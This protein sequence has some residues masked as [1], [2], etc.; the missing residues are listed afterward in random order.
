MENFRFASSQFF[1]F[2][3]FSAIF[4]LPVDS[5]FKAAIL[6]FFEYFFSSR[7]HEIYKVPILEKLFS[8]SLAEAQNKLGCLTPA[9]LSTLI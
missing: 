5:H 8:S 3:A 1:E 2:R 9:S 6:I 7:R 4:D